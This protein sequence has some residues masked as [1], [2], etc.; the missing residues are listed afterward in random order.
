MHCLIALLYFFF[1]YFIPGHAAIIRLLLQNRADK[2][3]QDNDGN[4]AIHKAAQNGR[5]EIVEILLDDCSD[6]DRIRLENTQN[7]RGQTFNAK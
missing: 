5:T 3:A 2:F 4:T 6:A 7:R 1:D